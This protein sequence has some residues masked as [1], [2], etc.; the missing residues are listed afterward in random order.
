MNRRLAEVNSILCSCFGG[1]FLCSG[2]SSF[3]SGISYWFFMVHKMDTVARPVYP[4]ALLANTF[5]IR[6][7]AV[8]VLEAPDTSPSLPVTPSS[9]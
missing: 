6:P 4:N 7:S 8:L 2:C 1:G 5:P 9:V 3:S